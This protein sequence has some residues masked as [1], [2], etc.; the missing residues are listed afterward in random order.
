MV[1]NHN[2]LT[3][4][5]HGNPSI[6][7]RLNSFQNN[8]ELDLSPS[9]PPVLPTPAGEIHNYREGHIATKHGALGGYCRDISQY[10][11]QPDF[12]K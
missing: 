9:G 3:A 10:P 11:R 2:A 6:G 12:Q 8:W 4:H 1:T 7:C 5:L